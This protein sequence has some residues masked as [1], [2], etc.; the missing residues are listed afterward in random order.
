VAW[1]KLDD[2]RSMHRKFR[3]EGFAA[4][5]LDEAAMCVCAHDETD[6]KVS[7]ET[8]E[9]L[10]HHHGVSMKAVKGLAG[11]LVR[12][13]RWRWDETGNCWWVKDYLD[14]NPSRKELEAKRKK[15]RDRKRTA[16]DSHPDHPGTVTESARNPLGVARQ[17]A[18]HARPSRPDRPTEISPE[19][20]NSDASGGTIPEKSG[21]A[22][23]RVWVN[24]VPLE[25]VLHDGRLCLDPQDDPFTF[26]AAALGVDLEAGYGG[27]YVLSPDWGDPGYEDLDDRD[28]LPDRMGQPCPVCHERG[29]C[30]YD[31]EGRPLIH[32]NEGAD[33]D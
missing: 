23:T 8:L 14:F 28:F 10:A 3:R 27:T 5:G 33:D 15:D 24:G 21:H 13:G 25:N 29:A 11:D 1:L 6:G 17:S 30:G 19:S 22:R 16:A 20:S 18:G 31:L 4:R 7:Q 2:K 32:V 12:I 9:D 26:L